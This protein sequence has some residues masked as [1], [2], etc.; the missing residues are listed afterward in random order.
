MFWPCIHLLL[1]FNCR[2]PSWCPIDNNEQPP[3]LLST[4]HWAKTRVLNIS[5]CVLHHRVI[6]HHE[7]ESCAVLCWYS[8]RV[9]VRQCVLCSSFYF[10]LSSSW[11]IIVFV[12]VAQTPA[13]QDIE[14]T[15][16]LTRNGQYLHGLGALV[17]VKRRLHWCICF[18]QRG[19]V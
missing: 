11:Y 1:S 2:D 9:V 3:A 4:N 10:N 6:L 16:F 12:E 17:R 19:G 8:A 13:C 15:G 14:S 18:K 7:R 5:C